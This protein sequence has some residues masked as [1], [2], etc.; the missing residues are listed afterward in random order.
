MSVTCTVICC[1]LSVS[2]AIYLGQCQVSE[3]K[4]QCYLSI[5]VMSGWFFFFL[6]IGE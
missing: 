3:F 6:C 1:F 5:A 2:L 4:I